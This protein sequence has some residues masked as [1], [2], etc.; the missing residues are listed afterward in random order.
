MRNT[1]L[2]HSERF[3]RSGKSLLNNGCFSQKSRSTSVFAHINFIAND[4]DNDDDYQ[5]TKAKQEE[6]SEHP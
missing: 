5:D 1:V 4:N 3:K 6:L 2:S